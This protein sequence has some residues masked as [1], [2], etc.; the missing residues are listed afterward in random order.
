MG[1]KKENY[2]ANNIFERAWGNY[3]ALFEFLTQSDFDDSKGLIQPYNFATLLS[4]STESPNYNRFLLLNASNYVGPTTPA[5]S[6][7]EHQEKSTVLEHP[8][9]LTNAYQSFLEEFDRRI[10]KAIDPS[11][12][13]EYEEREDDI[14]IAQVEFE[15]YLG[16]VDEKWADYIDSRPDIPVEERRSRRIE[17]ERDRG[18][19]Q[20]IQRRRNKIRRKNARLN[21]WLR[22][23]LPREFSRLIDARTYFDD[24]NYWVKLPVSPTHDSVSSKNLWRLFRMQFPL[25]DLD[26]FLSNDNVVS[27]SFSTSEEHY[28][29]VETKWKVK[30]KSRWG[31]FSGGASAQRRKLEELSTTE[32][33]TCKI[34]FKRFQEVEIYRDRWFQDVLFLT[35]GKD[36]GDFWGPNGMLAA[37]PVSLI[38]ARGMSVDVQVSSEYKRELEKFFSAGGSASFGP[39]FS[40]GGS[41]SKDERYMDFKRSDNGFTL[42]DG[43]QTVRIL[44][45]RVKRYN[46][47]DEG[48]ESYH[49]EL[50][51]SDLDDALNILNGSS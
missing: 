51:E 2:M 28:K 23:K 7:D 20:G 34:S 14:E 17:W 19:S 21:A 47:S 42:S 4:Y 33:F 36:L 40:G 15:D 12:E 27:S 5:M 18:Y 48:A 22:S 10:A 31:I 30:A 46:W 11:D 39:F 25:L 3:S 49:S 1:K 13:P 9:R 41:Y 29:R 35:V 8:A 45:G 37:V 6:N 38:F 44:G 26:E 50:S 24:E 16:K 32:E 43:D